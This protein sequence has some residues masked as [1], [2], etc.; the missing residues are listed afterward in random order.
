M[1]PWRCLIGW[2]SDHLLFGAALLTLRCTECQRQTPGW[3]L[4]QEIGRRRGWWARRMS[5]VVQRW[6]TRWI[7]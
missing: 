5:S 3:Q 7:A 4:Q 6:K 1:R 2:H